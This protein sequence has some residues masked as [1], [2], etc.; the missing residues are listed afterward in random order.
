MSKKLKYKPIREDELLDISVALAQASALL[1]NVA[2][3]ALVTGDHEL[4]LNVA[5]RWLTMATLFAATSEETE[6]VNTNGNFQQ[7][8]FCYEK[9]V[10]VTQEDD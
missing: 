6:T 1:D 8:G 4:I 3:K 7:Y 9:E 2:E 5:D 10:E